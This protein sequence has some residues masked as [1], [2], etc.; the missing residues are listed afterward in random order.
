MTAE[1]MSKFT[2]HARPG[3]QHSHGPLGRLGWFGNAVAHRKAREAVAWHPA[4]TSSAAL[5]R[6]EAFA[7]HLC[8][9]YARLLQWALTEDL[10]P[11]TTAVEQLFRLPRPP[12]MPLHSYAVDSGGTERCVRC[13]LPP[14]L[15]RDR[16]CRPHGELGHVP[17]VLGRGNFA[18]V[19]GLSHSTVL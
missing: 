8:I 15:A 1:M 6:T 19:A 11:A 17:F 2:G 9:S 7:L 18:A 5:A 16:P 4:A 13:M 10:L 12:P 3:A 14:R